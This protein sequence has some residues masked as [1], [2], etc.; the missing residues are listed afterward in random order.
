MRHK[1]S[2]EPHAV[3]RD[4]DRRRRPATTPTNPTDAPRQSDQPRSAPPH[5]SPPW[6]SLP[7]SPLSLRGS[8]GMSPIE[9]DV[10]HGP[11][12]H[13]ERASKML[14]VAMAVIAVI[15]ITLALLS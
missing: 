12:R 3:E 5:S 14:L 7:S 9:T 15:V 4:R 8:L 10:Q 1:P 2:P 11:T 13:T 6:S